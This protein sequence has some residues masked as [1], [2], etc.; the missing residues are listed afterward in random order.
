MYTRSEFDEYLA[1]KEAEEDLVDIAHPEEEIEPIVTAKPGKRGSGK[2]AVV[3]GHTRSAPGAWGVSPIS[4]NE[5]PF[6]RAFAEGELVVAAAKRGVQLGI[7]FR[8]GIGIEGAYRKVNGFAPDAAFE[9]HFNAL[10]SQSTGTETLY[11]A[12]NNSSRDL[13]RSI[14]RQMVATFA[15]RDRGLL[16]RAPGSGQ[17]GALSVNS[18]DCPSALLEPF[19]GSNPSD[20]WIG[21]ARQSQYADAIVGSFLSFCGLGSIDNLADDTDPGFD[22]D[23]DYTAEDIEL[24]NYGDVRDCDEE[25][26]PK[27]TP[28]AHWTSVAFNTDEALRFLHACMTSNPRVRYGYGKKIRPGEVPGRDFTAVDCSG[29][30]RELVRRS[31]N[32]GTR[33]PDGSVVQHEWV[34]SR[35]FRPVDRDDAMSRDDEVRIAFLSPRDSTNGIGHVAL[36]HNGQ[37]LESHGGV[38]PNRRPWTVRGW[39]AKSYVYLFSN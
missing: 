10:S 37:T 13:A 21:S 32:L 22:P 3:I 5:Y 6:N 29:L 18:A 19:F 11:G 17:R 35:H 8:D 2:L 24:I 26:R 38:G 1:A 39:Q 33:F 20:S 15:L 9:L 30:V 12:R 16:F 7:F 23:I 14:Q 36:V 25:W 27:A 31:T 34:R 28:V 4:Q